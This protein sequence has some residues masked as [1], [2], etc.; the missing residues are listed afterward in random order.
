MSTDKS[1]NKSPTPVIMN[2]DIEKIIQDIK[3]TPET[4]E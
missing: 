3:Y 2:E 1:N 4:S